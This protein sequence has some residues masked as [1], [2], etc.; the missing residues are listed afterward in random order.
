[1]ARNIYYA[2]PPATLPTA[3]V[4]GVASVKIEIDVAAVLVAT[5]VACDL[6]L[7]GRCLYNGHAHIG[8]VPYCVCLFTNIN[9]I[10]GMQIT[11]NDKQEIKNKCESHSKAKD[12]QKSK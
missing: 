12:T 9:K 8:T 4:H 10:N 11:K 7:N 3:P 1:M 5:C 6:S 2:P